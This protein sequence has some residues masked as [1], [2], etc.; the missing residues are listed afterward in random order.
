MALKADHSELPRADTTKEGCP[1]DEHP[2]FLAVLA[3]HLQTK[4]DDDGPKATANGSRFR[5]SDAGKCARALSYTFAG[6]ADSDPPDSSGLMNFA[7]GQFGHDLFQAALVEHYGPD[8][9]IEPT[10]YVEG[11]D[12]S[13]HIDAIIRVDGRTICYELKTLGGFGYK[14]A[15]GERGAA[16]GPKFEHIIQGALNATAADAD[17]MV[18]GYLSKESIS[19]QAAQ[20]KHI[21]E[22]GRFMAEWTFLPE[23]FEAV[24]AA[25]RARVGGI[26]NLVDEG[27]LAA[28]KIPSPELPAGAE[29]TDPGKGMWQVVKD[30]KVLDAGSYWACGYCNHRTLCATTQPGRIPLSDVMVGVTV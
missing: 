23:Q 30:G 29:I 10:C 22:L 11:F 17:E 5:H 3:D 9:E 19:V 13:G 1:P 6:I 2:R 14:M 24:A 15:V 21:S 25:E 16:G 12:G 27:T 26:L 20:R 18:I 4:R 7:F 28:R 8:A